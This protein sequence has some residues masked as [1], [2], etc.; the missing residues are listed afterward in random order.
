MFRGLTAE[1]TGRVQGVFD[2]GIAFADGLGGG[3]GI[4]VRSIFRQRGSLL[5]RAA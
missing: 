2:I 3:E 1:V 4:W 5:Q